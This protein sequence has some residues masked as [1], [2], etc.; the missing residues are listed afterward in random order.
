MPPRNGRTFTD[1]ARRAQIVQCA[2]DAIAEAGYA[3]TSMAEVAARARIA[4]SVISYHFTDKNELLGELV[5][6]AVSKYVELMGP[7]LDAE[8]TV[9]GKIRAYLVTSAEYMVVHRSLH[10]AVVEIAF[11][12]LSPDG[13]PLVG[14]IPLNAAET[15]EDLLR[16]GQLSGELG[17]FDVRVMADLLRSAAHQT[18]TLAFRADPGLDLAAY[19][20]QLAAIFDRAIGPDQRPSLPWDEADPV[21]DPTRC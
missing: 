16:Q 14:S 3:R 11:N 12:A 4:K 19:A 5:R 10:L 6:T 17:E 15:L 2:A 18:M 8:E 21:R 1:V 20:G 7:R 9:R 13:Q